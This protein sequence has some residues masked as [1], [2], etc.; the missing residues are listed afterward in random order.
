MKAR[1]RIWLIT[2][3]EPI[4]SDGK[5][6]RLLRTGILAELLSSQ[7]HQVPWWTS[8]FDHARKRH[9]ANKDT[10]V[11]V[12]DRY[13]IRMIHATDYRRNIGV[14][15]WWNHRQTARR[16]GRLA[17]AEPRPDVILCSL[18]TVELC[19]AAVTVEYATLPEA[20]LAPAREVVPAEPE[21]APEIVQDIVKLFN[22]KVVDKPGSR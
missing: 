8:T 13:D 12:T 2:V 20:E 5:G 15:R 10:T 22:A 11:A 17:V 14:R 18:P 7:G 21:D 16:F 6:D 1:M 19:Q 4:P 3:G 9:R